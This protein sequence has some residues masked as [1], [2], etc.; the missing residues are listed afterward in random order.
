M[1]RSERIMTSELHIITGLGIRTLQNMAA[2]GLIPSAK[3]YRRQWTFDEATVRRWAKLGETD[4]TGISIDEGQY[5]KPVSKSTERNTENHYERAIG[6]RPKSV[7][8]F[9]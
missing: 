1:N 4:W 3:K 9:G 5:G 8:R 6:L 7:S 2:Q